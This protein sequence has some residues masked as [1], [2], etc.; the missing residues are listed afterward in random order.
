M[1]NPTSLV[2]TA[3]GSPLGGFAL[4][5]LSSLSG[6]ALL[7]VSAWLIIRASQQPP[8]L[9]LQMA[10]DGVRG[11]AL[12]RAF[13]RYTGRLVAH[14][15]AFTALATVRVQVVKRLIRVVPGSR[16]SLRNGSVLSA[17]VRDVDSLQFAPLRV[18][19]PLISAVVVLV[20]SVGG[21]ALID[22]AAGSAVAVIA[23][24]TLAISSG[25]EWTLATRSLR[26]IPTL[27][28]DL[29]SMISELHGRVSV[30]A[31]FGVTD[32]YRD[33]ISL[34]SALLMKRETSTI[35][36]RS[37]SNSAQIV[38][39]G[40][41]AIL[42][43]SLVV[44]L[45]SSTSDESGAVGEDVAPFVGVVVLG[46]IALFEV[47]AQVPAAISGIVSL[48]VARGRID[49]EI[50]VDVPR[51]IPREPEE[52]V[53][54][55]MHPVSLT[56][57]NFTSVWPGQIEPSCAPVSVALS[58]GDC[59]L[60]S[61]DSGV[62]KSTIAQGLIRFLDH[63]GDFILNG[64]DV[65]DAS[66]RNVRQHI[67]LCEQQP[68]IFTESVRQNLL[69]AR[70]SAADTELWNVLERVRLAEWARSRTGLDTP[71]GESGS[72]ISG[73]QAHRIA[74]ARM[75]LARHN[76]MILDEPLA[77]LDRVTATQVL[78]DLLAA[79]TDAIVIIISHDDLEHPRITQRLRVEARA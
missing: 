22:P 73:G 1:M 77:H 8:I 61:G 28:A 62:G 34:Q 27:R 35:W 30:L 17:L 29:T 5:L 4:L 32:R 72:L 11:F 26:D 36:A 54:I 37:L 9:Y 68:H 65:R 45:G 75:L 41:A 42:G 78:D 71:L 10:I 31:A 6:V 33:R 56:L 70:D 51:E 47:L 19:E 58:N 16:K 59:L 20:L 79:T 53:V 67:G 2:R 3:M 21:I 76:I 66:P 7:S 63:S 13:F 25:A 15:N 55:P 50:P 69:F 44:S 40:L 12:A 24:V 14:H 23:V 43:L 52:P 57:R 48:H 46:A 60:V 38:G 18:V 39:S 74:V 49:S 64:V